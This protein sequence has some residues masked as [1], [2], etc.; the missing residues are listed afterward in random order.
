MKTLET[1][2]LAF[3]MEGKL[4]GLEKHVIFQQF[5]QLFSNTFFEPLWV[6]SNVK[7]AFFFFSW[8]GLEPHREEHC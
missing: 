7:C 4:G 6:V 2:T 3:I 1:P 8:F 5:F